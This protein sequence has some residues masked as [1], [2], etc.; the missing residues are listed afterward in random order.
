M[1]TWWQRIKSKAQ[2]HFGS[3]GLQE[4]WSG[5]K[6][7]YGMDYATQGGTFKRLERQEA[8]IAQMSREVM[9]AKRKRD[10][11][12]LMMLGSAATQMLQY[13]N[14]EY[15]RDPVITRDSVLAQKANANLYKL[16][17]V[18]V[19]VKKAIMKMSAKEYE[20]GTTVGPTAEELAEEDIRQFGA[21]YWPKRRKFKK[22]LER[23]SPPLVARFG[24]N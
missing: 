5:I 6:S 14:G 24:R 15:N 17:A 23:F 1:A 9:T 11:A 10:R 4:K 8:S 22:Y 18:I 13:L 20:K 7:R 2:K 3:K 19:G 16:K 21:A 12:K